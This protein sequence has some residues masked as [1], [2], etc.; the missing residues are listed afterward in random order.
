M[1]INDILMHF[2]EN[3]AD[4]FHAIAPPVIQTS[5]FSFPSLSAFRKAIADEEKHHI[6][7]RGNNPSVAILRKKIAALEHTEDALIFGSGSAAISAAIISQVQQGDHIVCIKK[8]YS[9]TRSILE[10]FLP[11][12][13]V[14]TTFVDGSLESFEKALQPN[15]KLIMLESPNSIT[16]EVQD[17]KAI[18]L[19]A[20]KNNII[21]AIDNSYCSPIYQNPAD[22]GI[23]IILHSATKYINGHSDVVVGICCSS[24]K[25]ISQIFQSEFMTLGAIISPHDAAL[26][27]RGLRTLPLRMNRIQ[28]TTLKL[29]SY[30]E[31]HPKVEQ[32]I[33]P[34]S[35][36]F[37]QKALVQKQMRGAGGM[38]SIKIK[39]ENISSV[40]IFF[41]KLKR[42]LLAVS[43]GGFES[44]ALPFCAFYD[45]PGKDNPT[46][47]WNLIRFSIGLEDPEW[48]IEDL[49]K[50]FEH[51]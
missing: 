23:D 50:A 19:L 42:F 48:L 14:V 45:L 5:N 38:F 30:L 16:F 34:W 2:G 49:E 20:K 12:F 25:I 13:G 8:P 31:S 46:I 1:D 39:A 41:S 26:V 4:Y 24:K 17:L 9:W 33:Y 6:Y 3:R 22:F 32:V 51:L 37:P 29:T 11:R 15:T 36:N 18:A 21:T 27:I 44:L 10:N 7:T 35:E 28:Q 47:P 40:E 43:W